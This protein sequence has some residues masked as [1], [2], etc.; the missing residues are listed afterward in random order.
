MGD[1]SVSRIVFKKQDSLG[2]NDAEDDKK[3]LFQCFVDTG[4]YDAVIDYGDARCLVLGRTGAGK[5]ALLT[6]LQEDNRGR[7]NVIVINPEALAMHHISNSTIIRYMHD[8]GIEM[9]TFFKLLWRHAICVEIFNHHFKVTTEEETENLIERLRSRFKQTNPRHLQALNYLEDWQH[10]FWKK[11]DDH[12]TGMITKKESELGGAISTSGPAISA[13]LTGKE[14]LSEKAIHEIRQRAK[15]IVD[16]TQMS[17][18]THLLSMLN[19]VVEDQQKRYYVVIDKLDEGWVDDELRY[20]LIKALIETVKDLNRFENIKP[21]VVLRA[22]LLG[23]VFETTRDTGFQEEKFSSLYLH[24][25]WTRK[26]LTELIDRRI[27]FLLKSRYRSKNVSH[28]DILPEKVNGIPAIDYIID[29][30]LMRPRDI[31][32]FF[33][34]IIREAT[35]N[36]AITEQ[37]VLDAGRV[38]SRERLDSVYYEWHTDYPHLKF[39]VRLLREKSKDFFVGSLNTEDIKDRCIEYA[40]SYSDDPRIESDRIYKLASDVG[41]S[42][43]STLEFMSHLVHIFYTV[44]IVGLQ[45]DGHEKPAWSYDLQKNISVEDIDAKTMV[46]IHPC[47]RSALNISSNV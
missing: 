8:L 18:V 6:K 11:S 14:K 37:M 36:P 45:I 43:L 27:D 12:V 22:D 41:N 44:G 7:K 4:D 23:H 47:F 3:F 13:R 28:I 33:N 46:H 38:Y 15:S 19:D 32:E 30:T 34:I 25:R 39:W 24:V 16:E 40:V 31:I 1:K 20:R 2:V 29:R 9:N 42:K 5:T 10:T 35:E 26:Q 17:Q 21:L